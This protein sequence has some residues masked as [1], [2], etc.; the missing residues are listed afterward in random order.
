[1][2]RDQAR[3]EVKAPMISLNR[4]QKKSID[5]SFETIDNLEKYLFN[6]RLVETKLFVLKNL[7][8]FD[9]K[10]Q[11]TAACINLAKNIIELCE[12]LQN[13]TRINSFNH[14]ATQNI[15]STL[16]SAQHE[17]NLMVSANL[18][19]PPYANLKSH[20]IVFEN[21]LLDILLSNSAF[22]LKY[23]TDQ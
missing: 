12:K 6:Q 18:N 11:F 19:I 13:Y 8:N 22:K 23:E 1:M 14:I 15:A 9:S 7:R 4:F 17:L 2:I 5:S 21:Q 3:T 10:G 20:T 16:A